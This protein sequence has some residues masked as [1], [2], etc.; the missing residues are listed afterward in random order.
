MPLQPKTS[1]LMV[2]AALAQSQKNATLEHMYYPDQWAW[3]EDL[4]NNGL[5]GEYFVEH[6]YE[7]LTNKTMYWADPEE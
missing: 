4:V 7:Y 5:D 1:A 6:V 2:R 3:V